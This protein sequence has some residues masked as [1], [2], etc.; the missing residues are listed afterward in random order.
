MSKK[1]PAE[2]YQSQIDERIAL[3]RASPSFRAFRG[4]FLRLLG[5]RRLLTAEEWTTELERLPRGMFAEEAKVL[6]DEF[7]LNPWTVQHVA[8]LKGYRSALDPYAPQPR[9][10]QRFILVDRRT[11]EAFRSRVATEARMFGYYVIETGPGGESLRLADQGD[12][13]E[14]LLDSDRPPRD[15]A[16]TIRVETPVMFPPEL[17]AAVHRQAQQDGRELLRRLGYRIPERLRSAP[18][19]LD[20]SKLRLGD[21]LQRREVGDIAEDMFGEGAATDPKLR[22]VVTSRRS[23]VKSRTAAREGKP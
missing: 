12:F 14:E 9:T 6:G 17:A 3:F 5:R 20:A 16:I 18:S 21:E 13:R 11:T 19:V 4:R 23:R 2:R 8:L 22:S 15:D 10:E 1:T 7:G